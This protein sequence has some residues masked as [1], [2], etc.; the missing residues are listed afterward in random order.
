MGR[1]LDYITSHND[2][3][4]RFDHVRH[5]SVGGDV[6]QPDLLE[7]MKEVFPNAEIYV[8]Y[9]CSEV[10]CMGCT[11]LVPRSA[12]VDRTYVGKAFPGAEV[13]LWKDDGSVPNGG[14]AP[15]GGDVALGET[16]E[17]IF[18]GEGLLS[19]YIAKPRLTRKKHLEIDGKRFFRTGDLGRFD[20]FGNLELL[21]RSDFQIK[22]RGMRIEP[23]EIE[24]QLRQ[25]DGVKEAIVAAPESEEMSKRLVA[26]VTAEDGAR[27]D[28]AKLDPA[29]IRAFLADRLPD[30]MIPSAF[31]LL[32]R[33]PLNQ[34]LKVDRR[35]LPPVTPREPDRSRC[36][37]SAAQ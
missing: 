7:A 27:E 19:E 2:G 34:N 4:S 30:Y 37:N 35:A 17:V 12:R 33:M 13:R 32:D 21:G 29:A 26:Y 22:L 28:G 18:A 8:I 25:A 10:A 9:G 31:V 36:R 23:V 5:A 14:D 1:T 16:G 11:Y 24:V 3:V 6:A 15:R 20:A